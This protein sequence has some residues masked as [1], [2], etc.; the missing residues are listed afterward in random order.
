[1]IVLCRPQNLVC[2]KPG[3]WLERRVND[4]TTALGRVSQVSLTSA[5]AHGSGS[6]DRTPLC[7]S[8]IRENYWPAWLMKYAPETGKGWWPRKLSTYKR[9]EKIGQGTY[10]SVYKAQDLTDGKLVAL[11]KIALDPHSGETEISERS[12][13]TRF[14]CLRSQRERQLVSSVGVLATRLGWAGDPERR[15]VRGGA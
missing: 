10:S 8:D 2:L 9:L 7:S 15:A 14:L 12:S 4:L 13:L 5:P 1:M 11:K 6:F 3:G